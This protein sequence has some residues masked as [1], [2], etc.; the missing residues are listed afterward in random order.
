MLT[1]LHAATSQTLLLLMLICFGWSALGL[2]T[3]RGVS[4]GLRGTVSI[5]LVVAGIQTALG[6]L[7]VAV[8]GRPFS[9]IHTLYGVSLIVALAGALI[10]GRRVAPQR[11]ALVYALLTMFSAGLVLRAMET[12][13][14]FD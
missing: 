6:L 9:V 2:V 13:G 5:G 14:R 4:P 1:P 10:Y 7:L 11:E 3:G 8:V 12:V